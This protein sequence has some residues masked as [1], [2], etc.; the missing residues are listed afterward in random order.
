MGNRVRSMLDAVLPAILSGTRW[1]LLEIQNM[2]DEVDDLHAQ[3][4]E[5][6]GEISSRRLSEGMGSELAAMMEATND[7]EAIGDI[8]ETNLVTLGLARVEQG[9]EVSDATRRVLVELHSVVSEALDEAVIAVTQLDAK[10]GKSVSKLKATVNS[11]EAAAAAHQANRLLADA[12]DR[13]ANYRLEIDVIANL[14]R[15]FYFAKRMA[16]T[17]SPRDEELAL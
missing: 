9:L 11:L 14:K 5:Y 3:I 17:T 15:V 8:V 16:R 1:T 2:D 10:A 7:L 4:I 6:L 12:P 13:I